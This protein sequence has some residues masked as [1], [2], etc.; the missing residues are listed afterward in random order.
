MLFLQCDVAGKC[1]LFVCLLVCFWLFVCLFVCLFVWL[2][3]FLF[4]VFVFLV[5]FVLFCFVFFKFTRRLIDYKACW[6]IFLPNDFE[7]IKFSN[8]TKYTIIKHVLLHQETQ[9]PTKWKIH[10]HILSNTTKD[11]MTFEKMCYMMHVCTV[12]IYKQSYHLVTYF[13]KITIDGLVFSYSP[14]DYTIE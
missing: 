7:L 10:G 12:C 3:V 2:V 4:F 11:H 6:D 1:C 8:A 14:K 9:V 5:C 13:Y